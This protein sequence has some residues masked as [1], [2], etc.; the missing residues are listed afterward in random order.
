MM[1]SVASIGLSPNSSLMISVSPL[2]LCTNSCCSQIFC[3]DGQIY[4]IDLLISI[5]IFSLALAKVF[6]MAVSFSNCC[7]F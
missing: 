1:S 5:Q 2:D 4:D 6:A 7:N 3:M